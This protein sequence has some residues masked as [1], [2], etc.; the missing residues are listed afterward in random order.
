MRKTG[1][2]QLLRQLPVGGS[3]TVDPAR[4]SKANNLHVLASRLKM[5]IA[6]RTNAKGKLE[7]FRLK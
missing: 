4:V 3:V 1:Q 2:T 5:K 6:T 7:V